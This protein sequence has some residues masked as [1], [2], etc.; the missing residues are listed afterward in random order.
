MK[1]SV[2]HSVHLLTNSA[3]KWLGTL[4]FVWVRA[5]FSGGCEEGRG[6]AREMLLGRLFLIEVC[7]A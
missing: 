3:G 2:F 1:K 4:V 7:V 6:F 5:R